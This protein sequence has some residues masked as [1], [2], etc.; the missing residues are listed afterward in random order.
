MALSQKR[1][2]GLNL[3][4]YENKKSDKLLEEA[5][6]SSDQ[7]E[8]TKKYQEMQNILIEDAPCV[9]LYNPYYLYLTSKNIKGIELKKIINPSKR[10]DNTPNWYTKTKRAWKK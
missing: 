10:F 8:R 7:D 1:D 5:R 4:L 9:F 6:I 2:P 3:S